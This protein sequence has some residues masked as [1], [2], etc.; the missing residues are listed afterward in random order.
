MSVRSDLDRIWKAYPKSKDEMGLASLEVG[1]LVEEA[2]REATGLA[3][4]FAQ[5][6]LKREA[7]DA[8]KLMEVLEE[9]TA[10]TYTIGHAQQT[11]KIRF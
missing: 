11:G 6:G 2:I 3:E 9:A 10:Y 7:R 4:G 1:R 5:L 8:R